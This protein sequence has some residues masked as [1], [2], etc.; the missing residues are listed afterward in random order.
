MLGSILLCFGFGLEFDFSLQLPTDRPKCTCS[1]AINNF[2]VHC[3]PMCIVYQLQCAF[4]IPN[5]GEN[6]AVHSL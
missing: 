1:S 3:L 6:Q 2:S 5:Q 4:Q